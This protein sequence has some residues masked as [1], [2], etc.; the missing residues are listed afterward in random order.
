M[1]G[2][3]KAIPTS[4]LEDHI[5]L[6]LQSKISLPRTSNCWLGLQPKSQEATGCIDLLQLQI[7]LLLGSRKVQGLLL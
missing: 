4:G 3:T 7:Q 1:L 5:C 6:L 2:S